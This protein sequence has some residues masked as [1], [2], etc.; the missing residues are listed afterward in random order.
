MSFRF[1]ITKFFK[2]ARCVEKIIKDGGEGVIMR[3]PGS[4]YERGRSNSLLKF[5]VPFFFIN[6]KFILFS[7]LIYFE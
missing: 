7:F 3:R 5:K 6:K 4:L 2:L 1:L